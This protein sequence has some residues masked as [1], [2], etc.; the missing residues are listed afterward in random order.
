M[1]AARRPW[2]R[3]FSLVEIVIALGLVSFSM[4]VI[5]ALM[6]HGHKTS[7]ESRLESVSALLS[8]KVV[9]VLRSADN[10]EAARFPEYTGGR[11]LTDIASGGPV[12]LTNYYTSDLERL[13]EGDDPARR[14]FAMVSRLEALDPGLRNSPD[15]GV[16]AA[17]A[18]LPSAV[19]T[20]ILNLEVAY[21]AN[22]P[23]ENRSTRHFSAILG[24]TSRD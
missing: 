11:T 4:L 2:D 13:T 17:L 1:S 14:A 7:R 20:V 15:A 6:A 22:A 23:A 5:F 9:S 19:N 8:G 12:S 24:R 16:T 3:A 10:W 21:P 18:R